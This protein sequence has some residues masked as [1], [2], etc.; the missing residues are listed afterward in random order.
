MPYIVLASMRRTVIKII[1]VYY[2]SGAG[3]ISVYLGAVFDVRH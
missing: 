3:L 1:D 2:I